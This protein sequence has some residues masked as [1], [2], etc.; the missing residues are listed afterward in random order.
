MKLYIRYR[1]MF[2]AHYYILPGGELDNIGV[3]VM[4]LLKYDNDKLL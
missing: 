1:A 4:N 3:G 2:M